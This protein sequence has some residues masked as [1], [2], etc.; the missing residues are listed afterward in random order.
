MS[1]LNQLESTIKLESKVNEK[2]EKEGKNKNL[3]V[4]VVGVDRV[5]G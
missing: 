1:T 4:V 5:L 2:K 3:C